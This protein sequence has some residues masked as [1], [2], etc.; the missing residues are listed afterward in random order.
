MTAKR[1]G[2]T[3]FAVFL[4]AGMAAWTLDAVVD[5]QFF[6]VGQ[7]SFVEMLIT[8]VPGHEI[9][10]RLIFLAVFAVLG[11]AAGVFSF[12][13]CRALEALA[14]NQIEL[15]TTLNS[16][17]EGVVAID[18][19]GCVAFVNRAARRLTGWDETA[20]GRP[21]AEIYNVIHP[22]TRR[23]LANL[24]DRLLAGDAEAKLAAEAV[25]IARDE[26]ERQVSQRASTLGTADGE[27]LGA[28]IAFSDVTEDQLRQEMLRGS[29]KRYRTLFSSL[30]E[31]FA[32]HA[33]IC[34][35]DG[36]PVDYRFLAANPAFERFTGLRAE[37]I[38][39]KT[40][41]EV[42][43]ETEQS[44]IE[45]YGKVALTGQHAQFEGYLGELD[46][47]FEVIA[48]SPAE[49]QFATLFM[50]T[51]DRRRAEAQVERLN[52]VLRAV[53]RVNQLITQETD[54]EVLMQG[55][56]CEL[57]ATD[58]YRSAWVA[59][60][61]ERGN[62]LA[63]C[64]AGVGESFEGLREQLGQ[65]Q[66]PECWKLTDGR[67]GMVVVE[68]A[69][70]ICDRCPVACDCGEDVR[71]CVRLVHAGKDYGL[72]VAV[73]APEIASDTEH[74]DLFEEVGAD[75]AL[76]LHKM[77]TEEQ[78]RDMEGRF[79]QAQRMEAI[80]RLAG[81]IA[82]DFNNQLTVVRGYCDLMLCD[83]SQAD[84][85]RSAV[86][87][88]HA[89][90]GRAARLTGQLLAYGRRQVLR[91]ETIDLNA[92]LGE[93]GEGLGRMIGED[94]RIS[95][96]AADDLR[97]VQT[98]VAQLEQAVMNLAVNA[99]DAMPDGGE[100]I[101]ETANVDLAEAFCAQLDISP[102]PYVKLVVTDTGAGMD[103][104]AVERVFDPFFTTNPVGEGT[105]LGM[106]RV[107][108]FVKQSGGHVVVESELAR[109]TA[110]TIYLPVRQADDVAARP[111]EKPDQLVGGV[112]KVLVVEDEEPVRRFVVRVL[113]DCGY[114][115][116]AIGDP[117]EALDATEAGE[118]RFDLLVAD[119]VMPGMSGPELARRLRKVQPDIRILHISGY[120]PDD[121]RMQG[122]SD[123]GVS[124]LAKPFSPQG[125]AAAVRQALDGPLSESL[126]PNA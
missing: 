35:E 121:I 103:A 85:N 92:A 114:H 38:V 88:I 120:A 110:V 91:N 106:A 32:L 124:V 24:T 72:L 51:T 100:L 54:R 81:G 49:R 71:M 37:D 18:V 48:Y 95:N 44:W 9:F 14:A 93:M 29:E 61:D 45:A 47:H 67:E 113:K 80:G 7:G 70:A 78:R 13:R 56:C 60:V 11:V 65:D 8:D 98:D 66:R 63:A 15:R 4:L 112:E 68:K 28:V 43:P 52:A 20:I 73:A 23:P 1:R 97:S 101:I 19:S 122:M 10:G 26:T 2:Y 40:V 119:V 79:Q 111:V 94:V 123:P 31:G 75:I 125:L 46:R 64:E 77:A 99:R 34:N 22:R 27:S 84:P 55:V 21:L 30:R 5:H 33:I 53:R 41:R 16:I 42:L 118:G 12:R 50:D 102:G 59:L 86:E 69:M 76:A 109:G 87:E 117:S 104:S 108:G 116:Q 6:H 90:S 126:D 3:W 36:H 89:A 107:Y 39:G 62:F 58:G 83:L 105:G 74:Q 17:A 96:V 115:V 57:A 25:L 82:H